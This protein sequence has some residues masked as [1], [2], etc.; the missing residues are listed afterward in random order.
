MIFKICGM[1]SGENI[2]QIFSP[3][4]PKAAQP[5]W[6]GLIFVESSPRFVNSRPSVLPPEGV[7][8]I[9]V[10][11]H[12]NRD[13][14]AQCVAHYNLHALQLHGNESPDEC[15]QLRKAFP[16][17][18]LIKAFG[19]GTT[20]DLLAVGDYESLCD[21]FI[22]DTLCPTGG[23]SGRQFDWNILQAY[24]GN[25]PFLLSGGLRPQDTAAIRSFVHPRCVGL[26]LNSGFEIAPGIKN[27][28]VL[29]RF[30]SELRA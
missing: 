12:A 28:E 8:R 24:T 6:M 13:D 29:H 9:G 25:C 3:T 11:R 14:V 2:A 10:F 18:Q 30:V 7:K 1:R 22:F 4:V 27:A 16:Q 19:I 26:D 21:Y 20:A 5:D 17:L 15:R 23:G